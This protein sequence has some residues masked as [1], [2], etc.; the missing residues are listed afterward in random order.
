M[1]KKEFIQKSTGDSLSAEEWNE[2]TGYTND[3]VDELNSLEPSP[4]PTPTP[5]GDSPVVVTNDTETGGDPAAGVSIVSGIEQ[6]GTAKVIELTKKKKGVNTTL[7]SGNNIN[8]EPRESVDETKG[9]NISFKPGDDIEFCSHHRLASNQDEV[10][11]KIIDGDDNPVKLQLNLESLTLTTKDSTSDTPNVLDVNVNSAKNT[12]GYLKVRAQAI[13]LRCEDH[14]GVA[15]QPKGFDNDGSATSYI[16]N[17]LATGT[18]DSAPESEGE[19]F[20]GISLSFLRNHFTIDPDSDY[21]LRV[22]SRSNSSSGSLYLFTNTVFDCAHATSFSSNQ[23]SCNASNEVNTL[24]LLGSMGSTDNRSMLQA[25]L[26]DNTAEYLLVGTTPTQVSPG[27]LGAG[28]YL[29]IVKKTPVYNNMNKIKFEHGGGDGLEFGTFNTEHTS[30]F[31]TDY[32]FNKDGVI[33][34]AT[35]VKEASDKADP[36][37]P[38]TA[39]KYVKQNDDFYDVISSS[40]PTCTWNDLVTI[41]SELKAMR[42]NNEG[43]W[44][45]NPGL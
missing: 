40:D 18:A 26:E 28:S 43:P 15:L 31:T 29:E 5:S 24:S 42:D 7:T 12:K 38:T 20:I 44:Q 19:K 32:R 25:L 41:I 35:R 13:D 27:T 10:S 9:G 21:I 45:T 36:S 4:T 39:Y 1:T 14:G 11:M 16:T 8:I 34:L 23:V 3:I 2:L 33:M 30:V 17:N 22:V 6:I 37:D